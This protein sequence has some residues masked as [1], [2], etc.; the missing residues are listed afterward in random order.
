VAG[1]DL[2]PPPPPPRLRLRPGSAAIVAAGAVCAA[3][4]L[5]A[6]R[7][8]STRLRY[9]YADAVRE[10]QARREDQQRLIV[11]VRHLRHPLRLEEIGRE[12]G[13][14]SAGCVIDLDAPR[15]CPIAATPAVARPEARP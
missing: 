11:E 3:L 8:D 10:E 7:T 14:A 1:Q 15:P 2:A 12:L 9:Q 6:L 4:L 13:L 5:V